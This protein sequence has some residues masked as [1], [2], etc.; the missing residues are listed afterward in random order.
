MIL[1]SGPMRFGFV[2]GGQLA[3]MTAQE[4]KYMNEKQGTKFSINILDPGK[5]CPAHPFVDHHIVADF[6]D[7]DALSELAAI[8]DVLTYEIELGNAQALKK[9]SNSGI[10]ILP[11][12]ASLEIIQDKFTQKQFLR[13]SGIPV[14]DFV[15]VSDEISLGS[16]ASEF[17]FPV[18]LKDRRDAYDGRGN[19][20]SQNMN[21]L[22]DYYKFLKGKNRTLMLEKFVP[23]EKEV[24]VIAARGHDGQI[25][26]FPVGENIH[27]DSI[28]KM[29][30]MPARISGAVSIEANEVAR[31]VI[32]AF[33]TFGVFGIEMFVWGEKVLV[34]E[35]AP[36]VHNTGHGTLEKDAF[37]TSQFEQHL[38]AISGMNLG[39][40]KMKRP[41]VMH[42]ILG[43]K[44][45]FSGPYEIEGMDLVSLIPGAHLHLYGKEELRPKRKMGHISVVES[46]KPD[47]ETLIS[48]A[49][50]AR[51]LLKFVPARSKTK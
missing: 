11:S 41:V 37:S 49:E 50:K 45:S 33:G 46:G 34:N 31:K 4:A 12:P 51:S 2:G 20:P 29:T 43:E 8:S 27:E 28:L 44:D 3:M 32:E 9:L 19:Y 13:D 5:N 35:V 48:R 6:R 7:P 1:M 25:A 42:N 17:G 30:I 47:M 15:E 40:T 38:R 24:S 16:N 22:L 10:K 21:E 23:F 36:R 26:T 18:M 14:T 39:D